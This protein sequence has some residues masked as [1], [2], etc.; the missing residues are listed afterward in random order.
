M[1]KAMALKSIYDMFENLV[2]LNIAM[3]KNFPFLCFDFN[4]RVN[5]GLK[6]QFRSQNH[7]KNMLLKSIYQQLCM[8]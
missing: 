6:F 8:I 2:I 4:S 5:L 1:A 7:I 3:G